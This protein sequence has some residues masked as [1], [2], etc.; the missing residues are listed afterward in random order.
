MNIGHTKFH[1]VKPLGSKN[2]RK[3]NQVV[4]VKDDKGK[5][6]VQKTCPLTNVHGCDLLLREFQLSFEEKSLPQKGFLDKNDTTLFFTLPY[7][8]GI[9]L[10]EFWK[11]LKR[12]ER[13]S[14]LKQFIPQMI[15]ILDVTHQKGIFHND[16]K[17]SNIMI[18]KQEV[19]LIDFGMASKPNEPKRKAL[20]TL[21]YSPPELILNQL[22]LINTTSDL[23]SFAM[24]LVELI[25]GKSI[26]T[27]ENPAIL[28]Q[29]AVAYPINLQGVVPKAFVGLLE[30]LLAKPQ[31]SSSPNRMEKSKL[32]QAIVLA[33]NTRLIEKE[34]LKNKFQSAF[35]NFE[36]SKKWFFSR[37]GIA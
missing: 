16:I 13:T 11:T 15:A 29:M 12:K 5:L 28:T 6:F 26:Y 17:P 14:F 37:Y 19:H 10:N 2:I 23:Y 22:H 27:H 30:Q 3:F 34:D 18:D 35:N 4:L 31:F 33:Q 8:N 7:K 24:V 9:P 21:N 1:F 32:E 20:Y 36:S 25:A